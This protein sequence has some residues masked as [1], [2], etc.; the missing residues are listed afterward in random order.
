M[1]KNVKYQYFREMVITLK[2]INIYKS[3]LFRFK[4][5]YLDQLVNYSEDLFLKRDRKL[6]KILIIFRIINIFQKY[7]NLT[8]FVIFFDKINIFPST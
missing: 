1:T 4:G 8:L 2:I 6:S 7:R 3:F 5:E